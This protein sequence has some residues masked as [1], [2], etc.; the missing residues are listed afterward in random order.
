MAKDVETHV[1]SCE[2]FIKR[3]TPAQVAPMKLIQATHPLQFITMDYLTIEKD[4]GY[5][6]ILVIVD[7]KH[8]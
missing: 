4:M 3:K 6:N 5:E 2:R 1:K 7:H 8:T